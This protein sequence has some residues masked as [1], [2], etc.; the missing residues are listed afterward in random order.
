MS[1]HNHRRRVIGPVECHRL[2]SPIVRCVTPIFVDNRLDIRQANCENQGC[3]LGR[4]SPGCRLVGGIGV[5]EK[6]EEGKS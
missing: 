3:F 6:N 1:Q 2:A 4:H 5:I